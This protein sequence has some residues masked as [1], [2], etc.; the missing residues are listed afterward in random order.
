MHGL[1]LFRTQLHVASSNTTARQATQLE[2]VEE[3]EVLEEEEAKV[4]VVAKS[5][6]Q[7]GFVSARPASAH[8]GSGL[9]STCTVTGAACAPKAT[10][11][12]H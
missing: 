10:L 1:P 4:L 12:G 9:G 5:E 11:A 3:E 7:L 8:A 2:E 6:Q